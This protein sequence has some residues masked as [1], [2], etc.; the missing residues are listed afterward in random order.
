MKPLMVAAALMVLGGCKDKEAS[1]PPVR[2]ANPTE[3]P[4]SIAEA[5][6]P[7]APVTRDA[8]A[9]SLGALDKATC[10]TPEAQQSLAAAKKSIAGIIDTV[11]QVGGSDPRQFQVMCAQMLL[12]L[13]RDAVKVSCAIALDAD[14]RSSLTGLVDAWYAQ[15]TEVVPTGHATIDAVIAQMGTLRDAACECRDAACLERLEQA[16]GK[17]PPM[18]ASASQAARDL[19]SK[20]LG[21]AARCAARVRTSGVPAAAGSASGSG[22]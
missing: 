14:Q 20:V 7:P 22:R 15:R 21:D 5:G 3:V 11:R 19:A 12:A 9:I 18:P 1:R 16:L 2:P 13:E 6:A 4:T 8:C 10:P 17:I